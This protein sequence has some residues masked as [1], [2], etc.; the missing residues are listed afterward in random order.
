MGNPTP[1]GKDTTVAIV[2]KKGSSSQAALKWTID[3]LIME[4]HSVTLVN[5]RPRAK[6]FVSE[7]TKRHTHTIEAFSGSDV[8]MGIEEGFKDILRTRAQEMLLPFES[9]CKRK[10]VQ[11]E[12]VLLEDDDTVNALTDFVLVKN[13]DV[14]V[15]GAGSRSGLVKKLKGPDVSSRVSKKIPYFCTLYIIAKGKLQFVKHASSISQSVSGIDEDIQG[16]E[17]STSSLT[18]CGSSV[19]AK[20]TPFKSE[21]AQEFEFRSPLKDYDHSDFRV[22]GFSSSESDISFV[23]SDRPVSDSTSYSWLTSSSDWSSSS[24]A[25]HAS[26]STNNSDWSNLS[27]GSSNASITDYHSMDEMHRLRLEL[28]NKKK[29]YASCNEANNALIPT[30]KLNMLNLNEDQLMRRMPKPQKPLSRVEGRRYLPTTST[31]DINQTVNNEELLKMGG[32]QGYRVYSASE[33]EAA[34]NSFS[35]SR[36][37]GRGSYGQ[38]FA[39]TL[40]HTPVAVKV[41]KANVANQE[42]LVFEKEVE[43]LT[44]IRH[45]NLVLLLGACPESNSLV[46]EYMRNGNL[47][48]RLYR[49]GDTHAL[50]WQVRVCIAAEIGTALYFLHRAKP[51][52]IVHRGLT[53]RNILL[54]HNNVGKLSDVGL[55]KLMDPSAAEQIT[56]KSLMRSEPSCFIDP[57]Y[58]QTGMLQPASDIYSFGVVILQMLT[59]KSA[60]GLTL[61]VRT[62]IS[63]GTFYKILDPAVPDWPIEQAI[64]FA[65]LALQCTEIRRSDRPSL[66]L[67]V[68]PELNRLR[69]LAVS[70]MPSSL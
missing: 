20:T 49:I 31:T 57:E 1:V 28:M 56:K 45:P 22:G 9:Y 23:S 21:P 32:H 7:R 60:V 12:T 37:I 26:L 50:P 63:I 58:Q 8:R 34:T 62:S 41:L 70:S 51:E 64:R 66:A 33:I 52:P 35:M 6:A 30:S 65:E 47:E 42:K 4:G 39:C 46:Y 54:D 69:R 67:H 38:V 53:S 19:T 36:M 61:Q 16:H 55:A 13:I 29:M 59:A 44:A 5:V 14:L 43:I 10:N 27:F 48:D 2:V 25:S 18:Y 68:L 3:N 40:D 24:Y 17:N 15:M 11:S